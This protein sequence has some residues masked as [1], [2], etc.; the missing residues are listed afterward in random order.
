MMHDKI[1]RYNAIKQE[2]TEP[3]PLT[4]ALSAERRHRIGRGRISAS[5]VGE[6]PFGEVFFTP[7]KDQAGLATG[8]NERALHSNLI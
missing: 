1:L 4:P 3:F 8:V 7:L 6:S 2:Q 5:L